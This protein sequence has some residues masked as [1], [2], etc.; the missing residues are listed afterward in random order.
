MA[1]CRTTRLSELVE[2]VSLLAVASWPLLPG[3]CV[4]FGGLGLL[5]FIYMRRFFFFFR[6][7]SNA[8]GL[9]IRGTPASFTTLLSI[10]LMLILILIFILTLTFSSDIDQDVAIC[11]DVD[12]IDIGFNIGIDLTWIFCGY[13]VVDTDIHIDI[14]IDIS[15]INIDIDIDTDINISIA[16]RTTGVA[17]ELLR[18]RQQHLLQFHRCFR[19]G[20]EPCRALPKKSHTRRTR[21][22][23][24]CSTA[25]VLR[26]L[27]VAPR[28]VAEEGRGRD[29]SQFLFWFSGCLSWNPIVC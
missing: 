9:L 16:I 12:I 19:C 24:A 4:F 10:V 15:G 18:T 25:Y 23:G 7:Y 29:D 17:R 3:R 1:G 28:G 13:F 8:S 27:G 14:Y 20:R 5:R 6:F 21:L 11:I 22:P 26:R 2:L